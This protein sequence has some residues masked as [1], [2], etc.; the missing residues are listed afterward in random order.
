M[1]TL[2]NLFVKTNILIAV[3]ILTSQF[4]VTGCGNE[5]SNPIISENVESLTNEEAAE[6]IAKELSGSEA[7]YGA[8]AVYEDA[9]YLV[10]GGS[11]DEIPESNDITGYT[12][13]DSTI[14]VEDNVEPYTY[15][16]EITYG[17]DFIKN[18]R[19]FQTW[20]PGIDSAI[21]RYASDGTYGAPIGNGGRT[22]HTEDLI[23]SGLSLT[24]QNFVVSGKYFWNSNSN[25]A[26][27]EKSM[28]VTGKLEITN[29][30]I[31]KTTLLV[32]GGSGHL[33]MTVETSGGNSTSVTAD[34]VFKS[35]FKAEITINGTTYNAD[36][37]TGELI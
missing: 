17:Y 3:M 16:F 4:F 21:V 25:S 22:A 34:I 35:N 6:I 31:E 11:V 28:T 12:V 33:E 14:I 15:Y 8:T 20:M 18:G 37:S 5:D 36:L 1:K 23:F 7:E 26:V 2:K 13:N 32:V 29:L 19:T 30:L 24:S 9:A 27:G 10:N